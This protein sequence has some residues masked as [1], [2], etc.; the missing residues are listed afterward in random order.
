MSEIGRRMASG[1]VD[2]AAGTEGGTIGDD[3]P[4]AQPASKEEQEAFEKVEL[5]A[6][7]VIFQDE[8][9]KSAI[10]KMLKTSEDIATGMGQAAVMV[11]TQLDTQA[12][13]NI[14]EEVILP[15]TGAILEHIAEL[16]NA[17]PDLPPVDQRVLKNA[18]LHM[19]QAL[20]EKYGLEPDEVEQM[21]AGVGEDQLQQ[22]KQ[23]F[24]E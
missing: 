14:P 21:L 17:V 7:K 1:P 11:M 15:A 3:Y 22:I 13:N 9:T 18:T 23:Q 24:E 8:N 19:E 20:A 10:I 16:A 4:G 5:A 2:P 6:M 12:N